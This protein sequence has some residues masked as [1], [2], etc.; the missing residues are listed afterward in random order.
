MACQL[1]DGINSPE[2]FWTLLCQIGT[3]DQRIP[4]NRIAE[5]NSLIKGTFNGGNISG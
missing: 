4:A 1:P 3:T 2:Q 5:R